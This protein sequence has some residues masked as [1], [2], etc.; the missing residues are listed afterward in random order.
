MKKTRRKKPPLSVLGMDHIVLRVRDLNRSI[1]FYRAVLGLKVEHRQPRLGLVHIRVGGQLIDLVDLKG[2]LGRLGGAAPKPRGGRNMDH[3]ALRIA[4]FEPKRLAA[5]LK[6]HG[7]AMPEPG[8][9][10]GADGVGPSVYIAD[11]D[12][13]VI[14][15]KGPAAA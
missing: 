1:R 2:P 9:R 11:P 8:R 13:N 6:R 12:G 10:F 15:L 3:V 7:I 14:E 4:R 5:Y